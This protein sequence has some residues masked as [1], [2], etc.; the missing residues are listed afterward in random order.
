[1]GEKKRTVRQAVPLARDDSGEEKEQR[2]D[3]TSV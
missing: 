3:E 1:M 2:Q